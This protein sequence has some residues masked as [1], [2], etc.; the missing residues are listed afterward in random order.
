[1]LGRYSGDGAYLIASDAMVRVGDERAA[2]QAI[3][4]GISKIPQSLMLWT[5][6]GIALSAHDGDQV[7]PPALFAFQQ[8]ARL[9]PDHPAPP[10][11]LG[12]AYV[13][14]GEFEKAK[15]YWQ[16]ALALAPAGASYRRDIALRLTILERFLAL[17]DQAQTQAQ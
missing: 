1:M 13:Q 17:Q 2:V 12:Q 4:G 9:S 16:R 15:P 3:L 5:G 10:F 11:F 8:A 7:S 6:L 14:A